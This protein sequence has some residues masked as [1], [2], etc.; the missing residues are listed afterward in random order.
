MATTSSEG[1]LRAALAAL[2]AS[3]G[4][5][6]KLRMPGLAASGSDAEQLGLASPQFQD[7]PLTPVVWRKSGAERD[8]L[9]SAASVAQITGTSGNSAAAQLFE[10]AVGVLVSDVLYAITGCNALMAAGEAYAYR[11]SLQTPTWA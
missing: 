7:L 5:E 6:A 8:L 3:G 1:A 4:F 10:D 9:L 11:L 2:H